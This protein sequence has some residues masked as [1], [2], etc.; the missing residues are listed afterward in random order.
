MDLYTRA[1]LSNHLLNVGLLFHWAVGFLQR[2]LSAASFSLLRGQLNAMLL[3][4]P[5]L[6]RTLRSFA[7]LR[8][9]RTQP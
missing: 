5:S 9:L 8:E 3:E 1:A 7:P 4:Q 2:F 6:Q